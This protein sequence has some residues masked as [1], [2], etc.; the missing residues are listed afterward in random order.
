MLRLF[1]NN[2]PFTVIILFI[3]TLIVKIKVLLHPIAPNQ[4][5]NHFL[6]NY[7]LKL[8]HY[9]LGNGPFA[10][11]L[12]AIVL[13][14][15][16]AIYL[17]SV[18]IRHKLF[19]KQTYI[20]AYV[21]LLLTSVYPRFSFF[22][23][24]ILVNWLLIGAMDIMFGF[25][26]N[27]QPRKLIYNAAMLFAVAAMF[28]FSMVGF[29]LLL[30]VGLLLFRTF[31]A[32]EWSVGLLGYL[33]PFYFLASIFFLA[34][35]L[36][37]FRNWPHIG[38]SLQQIDQ[39]LY[40]V[41]TVVSLLLMLF[42]GLIAMRNNVPMTNIYIR[43]DWI[44]ISFY[45]I[46]SIMVAFITDY[47]ITSAWLIVLPPLSIIITHALA[48]EKNKRFSNFIFYFSIIFLVFCLIANK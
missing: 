31:N 23:E 40:F 35:K 5:A 26:K 46:T 34:D 41:I 14:F 6:Y 15:M 33:T 22:S 38:F 45:L 36:Y 16:Q 20:A 24:G 42:S 28:Q 2:T 27:T 3:F 47:Y 44:A 8:L 43:R 4:I 21:Y 19:P 30:I 29:F 32:G 18:T 25:S 7:L 1:K 39:P 9:V 37:L 48:L 11:T 10:F 13:L 12:L 17:N